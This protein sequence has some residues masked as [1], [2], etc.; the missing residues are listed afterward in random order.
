MEKRDGN[1]KIWNLTNIISLKMSNFVNMNSLLLGHKTTLFIL[2]KLIMI[3]STLQM[4]LHGRIMI[5]RGMYLW[6]CKEKSNLN[7]KGGFVETIMKLI[8]QL[9]RE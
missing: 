7:F 6:L 5:Q 2:L 4:I 9:M 1:C 3:L 8:W